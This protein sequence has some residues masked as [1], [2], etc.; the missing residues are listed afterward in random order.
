MDQGFPTNPVA[1]TKTRQSTS[2]SM[3]TKRSQ[4]SLPLISGQLRDR[5]QPL[6][7]SSLPFEILQE[8][9]LWCVPP[10]PPQIEY[11]CPTLH[12][13][14]CS[15]QVAPLLLCQVCRLWKDLALTL[16]QLWTSLD[17][18]VSLG[19]SRPASALA[20]LWLARSGALPLSLGLFQQNE[21]ND[22]RVAAG[23][24]LDLY[25]RYIHR[26]SNIYFD[27]TGPRYCRLLTAQQ[28]SAP[29]LKRFRMQTYYRIYE[30]E[31]KDLFGIFDIVPCL[32]HLSV[33]RIPDLNLLGETTVNIPWSQLVSMS[34]DYVP[35][36]GTGLHLLVKSP[37]LVDCSFKINAMTGPLPITPVLHN[38]SSLLI[39]IGFEQISFFLEN[40][41]LPGLT[42]IT[43]YV[44]GPLDQYGWPQI[45]FGAFLKRSGCHLLHFEIHDTGMKPDD[46]TDCLSNPCLQSLENII[47]EDRRDWT[48]DPFVTDVAVNLLTYPS[49]IHESNPSITVVEIPEG[50]SEGL[51]C[52]LPNLESMT[53]RGS[54]LWT[55]DGLVADMV[56]SRWKFHCHQLR[57]LKRVNLEL[58]SSHE[59][60]FRRLKEFCTEGLELD[61]SFR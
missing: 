46:F 40:V 7:L 60:D 6:L 29:M 37:S 30:E 39:N 11:F 21:S 53:F 33:S 50:D 12:M 59:E 17:V 32:S 54:C 4:Y 15:S 19:K 45:A 55:V 5:D 34:L 49:L 2:P 26:W 20:K 57:R 56:E 1:D 58:L 43:I 10:R 42:R 3:S 47:V 61:L 22:N 48:W 35:S 23:E 16:P 13:T 41:S 14:G 38:M 8:I 51:S 25:K 52:Y 31:E 27:L 44:R 28:R 18:Y 24:I 36:V 9:F